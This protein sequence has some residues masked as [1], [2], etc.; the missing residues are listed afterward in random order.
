MLGFFKRKYHNL[1]SDTRFSEIFAGSLWAIGGRILAAILGL[2]FSII[3]ARCY[4]AKI[5]GILAVVQSFLL[6]SST[7]TVMGTGTAILRLIP[8]H[9]ANYSAAS[10][11]S[12]YHKILKMVIVASV[13]ACTVFFLGADVIGNKVFSKPQMSSYIALAAVFLAFK[14]LMDVNTRAVRG[15]K[16][17]RVFALMQVFPHGFNLILLAVLSLWVFNKNVPIYAFLGGLTLTALLGWIIME[18]AF[19]D[20][21]QTDDRVH[22]M[23]VKE[24]LSLS[25][26]MLITNSMTLLIGQMG[27]IFL[28]VFRSEADVGYYAAA[29]RLA[30]LTS[31]VLVSINAMAGPKFSELFHGGKM[32]ELFHVAKKSSKLIFWTSAPIL[33]GL[34]L[35]GKF[36]LGFLFG[37]EFI[38]AYG[39]MVVIILGQFGASIS[40]STGFFMNMTGN[41][42]VLRNVMVV[43]ALLSL[44][45]NLMLVP[46]M[47]ILGAALANMASLIF[48]NGCTLLL[49][50]AKYGQTIGYVP[51]LHR[52]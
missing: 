12:L 20:R 45:L 23:P 40:G 41:H 34:L 46:G 48:W 11:R 15:M 13:I 10:A 14:S 9:I 19:R 18:K 17:I 44:F 25:L 42:K 50:K 37:E 6:L 36:I 30:T 5:L 2:T 26:P 7:M 39:A 32:V 52:R 8:E 28:G 43:A 29:V 24:L 31:F 22:R 1:V 16:L 4:G 3:V 27:V 33:F 38:V 49:I 47:G 21:I 35:L 51:M